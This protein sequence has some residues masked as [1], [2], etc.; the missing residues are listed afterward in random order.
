M[1]KAL[2]DMNAAMKAKKVAESN[3]AKQKAKINIYK[4]GLREL[5]SVYKN[6]IHDTNLKKE[7]KNIL[8]SELN[9]ISLKYIPSGDYYD[10]Y[11]KYKYKYLQ[12]KNNM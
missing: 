4:V 8:N 10:K 11:L 1:Q 3:K 9:K 5:W 2:K 6:F 7:I 12:L